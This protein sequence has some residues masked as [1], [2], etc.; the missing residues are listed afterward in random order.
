MLPL[1]GI[2]VLVTRPRQ[3]AAAL[4]RLLEAQGASVERFAAIEVEPIDERREWAA[5]FGDLHQFGLIIFT[6]ANAVRYGAALLEPH[7]DLPLAAIGPATARALN[8]AGYRVSVQ[9]LEGA[10]SES[11]L[12]HP[13]LNA[14]AGER[15][16]LVKGRQGRELLEQ[17]LARRGAVLAVAEV[18]RRECPRPSAAEMSALEARFAAHEIHAITATSVE[19]A[20]NL[21]A[22]ATPRLRRAFDAVHWVVPS[23]R[24]AQSLREGGV[25]ATSL[26]ARSAEDQDLVCALIDWRAGESGA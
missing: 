16:L 20:A 19:I 12:R 1:H 24:V 14:V 3:Q 15:V 6:S 2:G 18:Y 26:L 21:L 7:R 13:K 8:Q 10:D 23:E 17:E 5:R 9:S 11:L 22:L 4:C 25:K